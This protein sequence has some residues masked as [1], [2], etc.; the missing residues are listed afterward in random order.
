MREKMAIRGSSREG[1]EEGEGVDH[2]SGSCLSF[3][4]NAK[5]PAEPDVRSSHLLSRSAN[6][7]KWLDA[8]DV[9]RSSRSTWGRPTPPRCEGYSQG[10]SAFFQGARSM[11]VLLITG[12]LLLTVA[13]AGCGATLGFAVKN[14][15]DQREQVED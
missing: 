4:S 5:S 12:N 11:A 2:R 13:S 6:C 1:K 7:G 10:A 14:W 15:L 8:R 3:R 9:R